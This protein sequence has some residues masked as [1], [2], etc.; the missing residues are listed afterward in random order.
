M[1]S[2]HVA[3]SQNEPLALYIL[4]KREELVAK[5]EGYREKLDAT[6][7]KAYRN[8]CDSKNPICNLREASQV[9]GIGQWMLKLLKDF[10]SD[11]SAEGAEVH[12]KKKGKFEKMT[13]MLPV[14]FFCFLTSSL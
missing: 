8:V 11:E 1:N 7:T 10:F 6:L 9:N 12:D 2:F 14:L 3:C 13:Q 4:Q 5:K